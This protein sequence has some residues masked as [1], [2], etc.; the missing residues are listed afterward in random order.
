ME[1]RLTAPVT[2]TVTEVRVIPG[3]K[4]DADEVVVV[5][6]PAREAAADA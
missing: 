2:G 1:H 6:T 5:V 4:I 3:Q